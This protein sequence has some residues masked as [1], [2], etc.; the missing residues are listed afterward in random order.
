MNVFKQVITHAGQFHAD[1]ILAVGVMRLIQPGIKVVRKFKVTPTEYNDP[2]T[3]IIDLGRFFAPEKNLFDHHQDKSLPASNLLVL[4]TFY[5]ALGARFDLN[6][7]DAY[8]MY[9]YLMKN[10]FSY[11]SNIDTGKSRDLNDVPTFNSV[12]RNMNALDP[13]ISFNLALTMAEVIIE[14]HIQSLKLIIEGER[15]WDNFKEITSKVR[16]QE[17]AR[18]IPNWKDI[19]KKEDVIALIQPNVRG[20]W[21]VVSRDTK[22]L[23]LPADDKAKFR[24]EAGFLIVFEDKDDAINYATKLEKFYG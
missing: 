15:E 24:H 4:D 8:R 11:V 16:L 9:V 17:D 13:E 23:I 7:S 5:E 1:E 12:I 6:R 18:I 20:G 14:G 2:L 21:Q 22:D 10:L 19:A 3:V